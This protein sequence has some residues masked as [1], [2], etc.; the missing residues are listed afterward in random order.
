MLNKFK[1]FL[2]WGGLFLLVSFVL[3]FLPYVEDVSLIWLNIIFWVP[4]IGLFIFPQTG[5]VEQICKRF[6]N[7]SLYFL[8]AGWASY[9]LLPLGLVWCLVDFEQ[10]YSYRIFIHT[11]TWLSLSGVMLSY[12]AATLKIVYTHCQT[13]PFL[14]LGG[15]YQIIAYVFNFFPNLHELLILWMNIIALL[16][17]LLLFIFPQTDRAEQICKR[18]PNLS[19]YFLYAGWLPYM[20]LPLYFV[21]WLMEM[22]ASEIMASMVKSYVLLYGIGMVVSYLSATVVV[23][24]RFFQKQMKIKP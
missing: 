18:F 14:L 8:Y 24:H 17:F 10:I 3:S 15:L 4:V 20:I 1:P 6:P 7:L 16:V 9:A 13:K 21:P 12:L 23:L 11:Y 2:L 5:R 22:F 19:L